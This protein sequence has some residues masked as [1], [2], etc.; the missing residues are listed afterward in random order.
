MT[1]KIDLHSHS[2]FSPDGGISEEQLS[3]IF[4]NSILDFLAITDHNE[5]DFALNVQS[6]F[7]GKI[8]VGEEIKTKDGEVIGLY[9]TKKIEK[10]LSLHETIK[11]IKEQN[12][13]IYLPH[14]FDL[15]R[16]GVPKVKVESVIDSID[17]I[18][19]FNPRNI[20]PNGNKNAEEFGKL[21]NKPIAAGSDA[22]SFQE[23]GKTYTIIDE[24]PTRNNLIN[25][26]KASG[27]NKSGINPIHLLNPK[28]NKL[29]KLTHKK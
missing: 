6:K 8:I 24:I 19:G 12:G 23:I 1:Y 5:V 21:F 15:R 27:L 16:A 3:I 29:K 28:L 14:P 11:Q 26:I 9:L 10:Y 17:I 20:I 4:K 13:I 7:P 25:L 18:E 22:H 2:T